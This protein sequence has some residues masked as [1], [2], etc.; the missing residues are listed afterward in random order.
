MELFEARSLMLQ[1]KK[2]RKERG[3]VDVV[4]VVGPLASVAPVS[5]TLNP[6]ILDTWITLVA[7]G[8]SSK[9]LLPILNAVNPH[10]EDGPALQRH[11]C[12]LRFCLAPVCFAYS[13]TVDVAFQGP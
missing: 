9:K 5:W 3:A 4:V 11:P 1:P 10:S 6:G 8:L 7:T 12:I 2:R 13:E